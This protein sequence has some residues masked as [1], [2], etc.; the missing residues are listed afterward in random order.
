MK[1]VSYQDLKKGLSKCLDAAAAGE[2][3]LVTRHQ[4]PV[5]ML[6]AAGSEHVTVGS[7]IGKQKLVPLFHGVT[8]GRYLEFLLDDRHGGADR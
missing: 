7:G 5:A 8:K 3:I 4:K 1:K 6:V 2:K